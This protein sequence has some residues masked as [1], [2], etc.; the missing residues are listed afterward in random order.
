MTIK[1]KR[2]FVFPGLALTTALLAV[3]S[4]QAAIP[5]EA[6]AP[7][8]SVEPKTFVSRAYLLQEGCGTPGKP[9]CPSPFGTECHPFWQAWEYEASRSW[10]CRGT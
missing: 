9:E 6:C 4:A 7:P 5:P 1:N 10:G 8:N 3:M 2:T